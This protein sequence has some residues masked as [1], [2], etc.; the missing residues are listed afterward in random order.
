M[1]LVC[2]ASERASKQARAQDCHKDEHSRPL[3]YRERAKW[4]RPQCVTRRA[5]A[6]AAVAAAVAAARQRPPKEVF[7]SKS[8]C[9][10]KR[11]ASGACWKFHRN[12]YAERAS[13]ANESARTQATAIGELRLSARYRS[14]ARTR[15][16]RPSAESLAL[17]QQKIVPKRRTPLWVRVAA[18]PRSDDSQRRVARLRS[19][20]KI[21]SSVE[22]ASGKIFSPFQ[23]LA[24]LQAAAAAALCCAAA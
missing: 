16:L 17:L 4:R 11:L 14:A 18:R 21:S 9:M 3:R 7:V 15:V 23:S 22:L 12:C 20:L 8:M 2:E 10:C 19:Q 5:A 24:G 13:E 1:P 6:A